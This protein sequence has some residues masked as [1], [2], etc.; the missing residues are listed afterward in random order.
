MARVLPACWRVLLAIVL[1]FAVAAQVPAHALSLRRMHGD[2]HDHGTARSKRITL[3]GCLLG[4]DEKYILITKN[5]T[6]ELTSEVNLQAR[7]GSKLR[8]TGVL[9][10]AT[11]SETPYSSTDGRPGSVTSAGSTG[12]MGSHYNGSTLR[13]SKVKTISKACNM[14]SDRKSDKSWTHILHL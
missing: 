8:V 4:Q 11:S 5:S 1:S 13:V 3:V 10:S 14:K 6:V 9:E 2:H 12:S 7:V